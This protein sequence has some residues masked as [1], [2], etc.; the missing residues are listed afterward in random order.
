MHRQ[1]HLPTLITSMLLEPVDE[2]AVGRSPGAAVSGPFSP[3]RSSHDRHGASCHVR[4]LARFDKEPTACQP[5]ELH[6]S[7]RLHN[8]ATR[9]GRADR[10]L[11]RRIVPFIHQ[12]AYL[13]AR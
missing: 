9:G 4:A 8:P 10:S 11:H 13:I 6:R 3:G 1:P 7:A 2:M 5:D 12:D